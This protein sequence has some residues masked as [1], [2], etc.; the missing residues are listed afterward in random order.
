MG[1]S[2]RLTLVLTGAGIGLALWLTSAA[3]RPVVTTVALLPAGR[4][5]AVATGF[6]PR[7]H[8]GA[9]ARTLGLAPVTVD[10]RGR[11][12]VLDRR[13]TLWLAADAPAL[14][15][16]ATLP[17]SNWARDLCWAP[18]NVLWVA[19][20][21]RDARWHR[22]LRA[23]DSGR[24]SWALGAPEAGVVTKPVVP[25]VPL[26]AAAE[27]GDRFAQVEQLRGDGARGVYVLDYVHRVVHLDESGGVLATMALDDPA[28]PARSLG[29]VPDGQSMAV[30]RD[31][32]V[33]VLTGVELASPGRVRALWLLS[34]KPP[35]PPRPRRVDLSAAGGAQLSSV[36][37]VGADGPGRLYFQYR[38]ARQP[39]ATGTGNWQGPTA[40]AR[41][42][43]DGQAR[44]VL[45]LYRQYRSATGVD[46]TDGSRYR[47]GD[48]IHVSPAGE[49]YVEMASA[50][51]YRVDRFTGP[52]R[53][54]AEGE[55]P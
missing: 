34:W 5:G 26:P 12:Y 44:Q 10:A 11:V 18:P 15:R 28:L 16:Q 42:G 45:D 20:C 2:R 47:L 13:N 51:H 21:S 41:C 55:Q 25:P 24:L 49:I 1:A 52:W 32:T 6:T 37:L 54:P 22:V 23:D 29:Y 35:Q 17:W 39:A 40:V 33:V 31:G 4:G 53:Q 46:A 36:L 3:R 38:T 50:T 14:Q 27:P 43:P 30:E 19:D 8:V 48:V 7:E 9:K